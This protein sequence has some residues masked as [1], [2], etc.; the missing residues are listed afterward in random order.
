MFYKDKF[1]FNE[2]EM[3]IALKSYMNFLGYGKRWAL[4]LLL[5][6]SAWLAP[7]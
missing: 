5:R 2:Q 3:M 4:H 1:Q 6:L 7:H